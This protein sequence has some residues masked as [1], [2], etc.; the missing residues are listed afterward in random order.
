MA[1]DDSARAGLVYSVP[2]FDPGGVFKG[3]VTGVVLSGVLGDSLPLGHHALRNVEHD[4]TVWASESGQ[5]QRSEE[6]LRQGSPDPRLAYSEVIALGN[7]DR[8]TGW[9]LWAGQPDAAFAS[10]P[11]VR[12][13]RTLANM[14]YVTTVLLAL[15][16][17]GVTHFSMQRRA[18]LEAQ[19]AR[20]TAELDLAVSALA[21]SRDN[22]RRFTGD[23]AHELR[24]PLAAVK[25]QAQVAMRTR[26]DDARNKA[27][28]FVI[29]SVDRTTRLVAQLLTLARM[30]PL[31]SP[32]AM[33]TV[34]LADV[35]ARVLAEFS[36]TEPNRRR[37][38][39]LSG[40]GEVYV[41]GDEAALEILVRNLVDNALRYS[42]PAGDVDVAVNLDAAEALLEVAD[43]GPGI[44]RSQRERV[45]D[46]IY[47][48][49][50]GK[51]PGAGLGLSIVHRI[52]ELHDA[53]M[54]I[55]GPPEHTGT[56]IRIRFRNGPAALA[57]SAV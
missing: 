49:P 17:V 44:P 47:R 53:Q 4:Y 23:A 7:P 27:L 1:A 54:Q 12:A 55:L 29:D 37:N 50:G 35:S 24:T 40:A 57:E 10:M 51:A 2:V 19:A 9:L 33:V 43:T 56:V 46:R 48:A 32:S 38:M 20:R 26:N 31:D 28:R 41:T 6:W 42:S 16:G 39:G 45:K 21:T 52:V 13:G 3:A 22:E 15:L 5:A 11:E 30:D 34:D 36:V 25:T 14:G 8:G 18:A